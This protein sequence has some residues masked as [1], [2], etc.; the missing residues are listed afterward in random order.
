MVKGG[1]NLIGWT[2]SKGLSGT[3]LEPPCGLVGCQEVK[4]VKDFTEM[5][6]PRVPLRDSLHS[7]PGWIA[8][9]RPG[10]NGFGQKEG[11]RGARFARPYTWELGARLIFL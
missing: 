6:G 11:M 5:M 8:I 2:R 1:I 7:S 9:R 4:L 10:D 3:T